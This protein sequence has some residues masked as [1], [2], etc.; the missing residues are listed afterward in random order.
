MNP[1]NPR[2]KN[3]RPYQ[4][5]QSG[6]PAGLPKGY[7]RASTFLNK[8]LQGKISVTEGGKVKKVT[9]HEAILLKAINDA[10]AAPTA[11]ERTTARESIYNRIEGKPVQPIGSIVEPEII[12]QI[13]PTEAKV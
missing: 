13:T 2:L 1:D 8:F 12:L 7:V 10:I 3:L 9:R 11:R 5:G 4:K 6:N